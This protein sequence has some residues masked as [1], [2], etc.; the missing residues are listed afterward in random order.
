MEPDRDLV[1][2]V[3][4]SVIAV[5]LFVTGLVVLSGAYGTD[6]TVDNES[7]NGTI[8][9]DYEGNI[10]DGESTL[11]FSGTFDNDIEAPLEGTITATMAN[12]TL[13]GTFEGDISG[14]IEGPTSGTVSDG[15]IDTEQGTLE[16]AFEG[17]ASG[18]TGMDLT[19]E[20]GVALIVLMVAFIFAMPGFGLLIER[21]RS[22][23]E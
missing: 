12:E 6:V 23:E 2:Q 16:A 10:S 15:T 14:P 3:A 1:L 5:G 8:T 11:E 18:T 21:L 13:S 19:A 22:D 7:L 9:G 17:N 20:G 4:L